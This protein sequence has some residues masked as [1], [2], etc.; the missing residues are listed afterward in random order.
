[1]TRA[2]NTAS[3]DADARAAYEQL[4][5]EPARSLIEALERHHPYSASHSRRVAW[6][7]WQ[8]AL[9]LPTLDADQVYVAALLHDVG[10][11]EI[12]L[13][14]LASERGLTSG[15]MALMRSHAELG[16]A[17]LKRAG[18]DELAVV[19]RSHHERWDGGGYPD[20][21]SAEEIPAQA[22]LAAA[23]DSIEAMTA[24]ERAW[25]LPLTF[26]EARAALKAG[27]GSQFDP[28]V[29]AALDEVCHMLSPE[30]SPLAAAATV[31]SVASVTT[32]VGK[33]PGPE[34]S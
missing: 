5:P 26:T 4:A 2:D 34:L 16:E 27:S 11:A 7:S 15:E 18:L 13:A 28:R 6:L 8:C 20:G 1:M 25:R 21:L 19:A 30:L 32:S 10:K 31:A 14:V 22:R 24:S 23:C 17:A 33:A 3:I 9:R 12:P 29:V